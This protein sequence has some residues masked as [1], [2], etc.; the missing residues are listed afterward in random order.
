VKVCVR[1]LVFFVGKFR[2]SRPQVTASPV[3]ESIE[4]RCLLD[5]AGPAGLWE[6]V[7]ISPAV[8]PSVRAGGSQAAPAIE[9]VA[10]S[11]YSPDQTFLLHSNPGA[12]KV[13]Y[14]D[15]DGHATTGTDWNV[16]YGDPITTPAFSFEGDSSFSDSELSR[17]QYIWQR[18]A[19][20]YLPF[21]VDVTTEYPGESALSKSNLNDTAYGV[22]MCIGG[23]SN[24][25]GEQIGGVA[26]VGSF[27]WNYDAPAFVFPS[28][29]GNNEK[30]VAEAITHEAGHTLDLYHDGTT[31]GVEYYAGHGSGATGW[32]P[33][34]GVGYYEELVQWSKG[35]YADANNTEDDLFI[36]AE[37]SNGSGRL[38]YRADDHGDA[39]T[40]ASALVADGANVSGEGIIERNTDLDFFSFYTGSGT[41]TLSV[42]PAARGPNLDILAT[43][44]D[45]VGAVVDTSNPIG[46]L[47]ASFSLSLSAGTYYLAIDGTGEGDPLGNGYSDYASLGY[48]SISGT[49]VA[50]LLP[51]VKIEAI[52]AAAAEQGPD[53]AVLRI[54]RT[55][56]TDAS[57]EV[58]YTVSGSADDGV[59]YE[60]IGTSTV[61]PAGAAW[62]DVTVTPI[63]DPDYEGSETVRL[64]LDSHG[65]YAVGSPAQAEAAIEDNDPAVSIDSYAISEGITTGTIV[66]SGLA[67]TFAA[68]DVYEEL[69]EAIVGNPGRG[70]SALSHT[71]TFDLPEARAVTFYAEAHHTANS[72]GD[73]FAFE[74][75]AD[76][77][78]W[79]PLLTVTKTADDDLAQSEALPDGQAGT[80]YVRVTDTDQTARARSLDSLY[81]DEMF[82]RSDPLT[83]DLHGLDCNVPGALTWGRLFTVQGQVRNLGTLVVTPTFTQDFYL[84]NNLTWG[85]ADDRY[86]G[87]YTHTADVPANGDGPDFDVSLTLPGT[88]PAGYEGTG[89]FYIGMQTDANED[90][91]EVD[92]TNN[93]PGDLLETWDWDSFAIA[94]P[95][96]VDVQVVG[97]GWDQ[98]YLDHLVT[99]GLGTGGYSI[100]VG[101]VEQ[102]AELPWVNLDRVKIVFS[103]NVSV[104]Q[105]HLSVYGVNVAQYASSG[106][107]YDSNT[108]TGTWTF[109]AAFAA[110]KLLLVLS[111]EVT[112][113]AGNALDGEWTD[114]GGSWP[115][116]DGAA[117]GEFRFRLNVLPGD[118][119]G[120]G[121]VR[122]SDTIKVRRKSNT[123]PGDPDYLILYDVD[124]S[125]EIR[126]SDTIKVR[127]L[128]NTEL[129]ADEPA[130]PPSAHLGQAVDSVLA[131]AAASGEVAVPSG[132]VGDPTPQ[133]SAAE[134]AGPSPAL[135]L[136]E[137]G[138]R[139]L[140]LGRLTE[141]RPLR[142]WIDRSAIAEANEA[143]ATWPDLE[144]DV[145]RAIQPLELGPLIR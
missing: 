47:D 112:D 119:D 131:A 31:G 103:E 62:A 130:P 33:I 10:A 76:G 45:E 140:P 94:P 106:F 124:G 118:V 37:K 17:I 54:S 105:S 19:E 55:G 50:E 48:Y 68:D 24:W 100:P 137:A 83:H 3:L 138:H 65:T 74:W 59:D 133:N 75:S 111:D 42:S 39:S 1:G 66:G 58:Y 5:G 101:S 52:D 63:D 98:A 2:P 129:P 80:V 57:L 23:N 107:S 49:V 109:A 18:V 93:G 70:H 88:A 4:P 86:L 7:G 36:I 27:D 26:Y 125:G 44:Y 96:V 89:P 102:L 21:N 15:F 84:S 145:L 30:Y 35:E 60:A 132:S 99:E 43:L 34:M 113:L 114:A 117:E 67:D 92:E 11:P 136:A 123:G 73:D 97:T 128:S 69:E 16:Q 85:D 120:S 143:Q 51:E 126:S 32:A 87:S 25:F 28:N 40:S 6:P 79:A 61:I 71:W 90:I 13:I 141:L 56:D 139:R 22:R 38:G 121:E 29:L 46:A 122:S 144:V 8:D 95:A 82:I 77:Q 116:G 127:R 108:F 91:Q 135:R 72:E 20:D 110:D 41:V 14:L 115:S 9:T 78:T 142:R 104:A 64:T 134:P 12:S 53:P 81:V